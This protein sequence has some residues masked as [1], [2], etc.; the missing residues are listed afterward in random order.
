M[1]SKRTETRSRSC[2]P[3]ADKAIFATPSRAEEDKMKYEE[4]EDQIRRFKAKIAEMEAEKE[5]LN[6]SFK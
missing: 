4:I 5:K 1:L 3:C 6:I 2:L